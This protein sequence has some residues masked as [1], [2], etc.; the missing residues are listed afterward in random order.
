MGTSN[1]ATFSTSIWLGLCAGVISGRMVCTRCKNDLARGSPA[2]LAFGLST[3]YGWHAGER[4]HR[5]APK[6]PISA[7]AR[8]DISTCKQNQSEEVIRAGDG[9]GA[10]CPSRN[11]CCISCTRSGPSQMH[12]SRFR[13]RGLLLRRSE[14]RLYAPN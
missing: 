4:S 5:S 6:S 11:S 2:P 8:V 10:R 12:E 14:G 1:P 7:A 13:G 3:V 9:P